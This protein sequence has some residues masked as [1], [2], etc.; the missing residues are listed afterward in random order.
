[1]LREMG[2]H[3]VLVTITSVVVDKRLENAKVK[4]GILPA[5]KIDATLRELKKH[6]GDLQF[7]LN[8]TLNIRPMPRIEFEIDHGAENA[9]KV[10]KILLEEDNSEVGA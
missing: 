3:G 6:Q 2:F 8:R 7:M 1:M 4:V 10:E 5:D 9:A